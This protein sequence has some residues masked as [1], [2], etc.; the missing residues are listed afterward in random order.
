MIEIFY[1]IIP[2]F[3]IIFIGILY[4][5]LNKS[6]N[7]RTVAELN[8]YTYYLGFPC[9]ILN[10][11]LNINTLSREII[12]EAFINIGLLSLFFILVL[13]LTKLF[14]KEKIKQNTY[15]ICTFFG[16]IAYL[17]FPVVYSINPNYSTNI[18][19][20]IAGYLIVLFTFGIIQL[21]I[22]RT[23][24][25]IQPRNIVG[26]IIINPLVFS[27][28]IGIIIAIVQLHIPPLIATTINLIAA[29]A[30]PIVLFAIGIFIIKNKILRKHLPHILSISCIKLIILPLF[31][32]SAISLFFG[33][34]TFE[35]SIM[36]ACMPVAITPFVLA[37]I[38]ELE[39]E[40]IAGS[41]VLST[42]LSLLTIPVIFALSN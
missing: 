1:K 4:G 25:N 15:L 40:I 13:C 8:K 10:S 16:N 33:K 3:A 2:F 35:V 7:D 31:F 34:G 26:K 21:E 5:F 6:F 36:M 14:F 24:S 12:E 17:G 32:W 23:N 9:I 27:T 39:K 11:F 28:I 30:S 22:S 20:H 19:F 37:E 38:Y 41:I 18:S 29:S 42:L